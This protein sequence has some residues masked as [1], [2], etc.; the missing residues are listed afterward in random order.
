MPKTTSNSTHHQPVNQNLRR[1]RAHHHQ[2][3]QNPPTDSGPHSINPNQHQHQT[4]QTGQVG[5]II[6]LLTVVLL[7]I[8]VSLGLRTAKEQQTTI[9]TETGTRVFSAAE[10]SV[11]EALS[12]IYEQEK[13][14]G[15]IS[16]GTTMGEN[17]QYQIN[18]V[19]EVGLFLKQGHVVQVEVDANS[20][21]DLE[22]NWA[23]EA[24]CD[25]PSNQPAALLVSTFEYDT[26]ANDGSY[27]SKHYAYDGCA[28][29]TGD[30]GNNFEEADAASETGYQYGATVTLTDLGYVRILPV[31]NDTD[32]YLS[33]GIEPSQYNIS[34]S[35]KSDAS[36]EPGVTPSPGVVKAI[37]V[38]RTKPAAPAFMEFALASG[39]D[40]EITQP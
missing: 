40:I 25:E 22:I 20:G 34:S 26:D 27:F 13:Q 32:L 18:T 7:T 37:E 31:Y 10:S 23:R 36:Q 3:H 16:D 11:E 19:Q 33:G 38:K 15:V 12:A 9:E 4:S 21:S 17:G 2:V 6:I 14:G 28:N 30:R 1:H 24:S 5:I 35:A 8:G 29:T 39:G